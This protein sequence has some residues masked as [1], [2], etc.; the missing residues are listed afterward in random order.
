MNRRASLFMIAFC[1]LSI[2]SI[3]QTIEDI[4]SK[5]DYYISINGVKSKEDVILI[6]NTIRQK[7]EVIYFAS[8]RF[9]VIYYLLKSDS[10]I[11][12]EKLESWLKFNNRFKVIYLGLG[13]ESRETAI[14]NSLQNKN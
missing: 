5:Y 9:P 2:K 1:F 11:T 13:F 3:S 10:L 8:E 14:V 4:K 7:K 12:K 6:E